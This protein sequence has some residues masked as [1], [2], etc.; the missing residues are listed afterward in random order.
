MGRTV[1]AERE[2]ERVIRENDGWGGGHRLLGRAAAAREDW[3]R[4]EESFRRALDREPDRIETVR[5][6]A[7]VR[8]RGGDPASALAVVDGAL[9]SVESADLV[10]L[11]ARLRV[12]RGDLRGAVESYRR[13]AG[14]CPGSVEAH[15]RL[16]G[17]YHKLGD[18][19][20]AKE[21]LVESERC[22]NDD[23][24]PHKISS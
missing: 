3:A 21:H 12:V 1:E 24:I 5:D 14:L 19:E 22:S 2:A 17:L 11:Q 10:D 23:A 7:V 18:S 15:R 13:L 16:A 8:V 9:R 20:K 4:A 6:L